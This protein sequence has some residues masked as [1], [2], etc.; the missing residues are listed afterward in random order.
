MIETSRLVLTSL[1]PD[2]SERFFAYRSDEAVSLY[3]GWMP[4]DREAA[5]EFIR[6]Q[7][8]VPFGQSGEW[9]QLA[10]RSSEAGELIGDVGVHFP[11]DR[12][13]ALELGISICSPEQRKGFAKEALAGCI[14]TAFRDWGYRRIVASVDPRNV[15]S[16]GLFESLGFRKEAHHV[17]SL[18][19]RGEWADDVVFALLAR[20]WSKTGPL[21]GQ[22]RP[23]D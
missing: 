12:D 7:L 1:R 16:M 8:K 17:E 6:G 22:P 18:W 14:D 11:A 10:I 20:E 9:C 23:A 4:I 21:Q 13:D 2:D 15:A 19:F 5:S 3:Q